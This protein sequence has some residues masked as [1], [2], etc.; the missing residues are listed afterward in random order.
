MSEMT[1]KNPEL[2]AWM[3]AFTQSLVR[4]WEFTLYRADEIRETFFVGL[5]AFFEF[6]Q[7]PRF[8]AELFGCNLRRDPRQVD[9]RA[10]A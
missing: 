6:G 9:P 3:S 7:S 1:Y 2:D 4:D 10:A 8:T 5:R